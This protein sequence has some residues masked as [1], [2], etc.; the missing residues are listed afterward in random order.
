[1]PQPVLPGCER[2]YSI[3]VTG[4]GGTGVITIGGV[5]GMA[6][7]LEGKGITVLDM[8]GLSQ[9]NGAVMSHVRIAERAGAL[10]AS[11]IATGD[12]DAV[13]GCD[14]LVAVAPDALSRMQLGLTRCAVNTAQ[15]MP[16]SFTQKPDLA[17][18]LEQIR[19]QLARAVGPDAVRFVDATRLATSLCGDA[20]ATN[21][22][23][24]GYAWQLGLV[25]LSEAAILR[26]VEINGAAV[27]MNT[28]AF[29][30][31][32]LAAHDLS[33]VETAATEA[34]PGEVPRRLAKTLDEVV[35]AREAELTDYQDRGYAQ[36]YRNLV[37]RVRLVEQQRIPGN[38][39]LTEA[40][41]RSYHKLLA[42]KDEYEVARLHSDPQF[43][44]QL[45]DTFE[46]DYRLS[47]HL[48]PPLLSRVDL[49]TGEPRK[50]E[51][52]PWI[53]P[54]LRVLAGLK[55]LRGTPFDIFGYTAERRMER[56]LIADYERE[57]EVLMRRLTPQTHALTVA[58]ARL[59]QTIRGFGH[60]KLASVEQASKQ[61]SELLAAILQSEQKA[62]EPAPTRE[63]AVSDRRA[64]EETVV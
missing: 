38:T 27:R 63:P 51:F 29:R 48:A 50:R 2:P 36:R 47:V 49:A 20:I 22:F 19:G 25:P 15:I 1:L 32:R 59:P 40:V 14:I 57:V 54:V 7:H 10:H 26:A 3:L 53:F 9:K 34:A 24:L 16:G 64:S 58:I 5:L 21:M 33:L 41:A 35:A 52:G 13:I 45:Q 61:R 8:T 62:S 6:S 56:Q 31:G 12:A 4:V 42:Y 55:G 46:G 17:F 18:P 28:D 39:A 43:R 23:L 44:R 30:W 60:V 11:R 37:E